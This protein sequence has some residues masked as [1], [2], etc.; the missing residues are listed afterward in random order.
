MAP[1]FETM[2][3]L[4]KSKSASDYWAKSKSAPPQKVEAAE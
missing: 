4:T 3:A 1:G 2:D